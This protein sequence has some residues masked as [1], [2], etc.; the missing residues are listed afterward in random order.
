MIGKFATTTS[1]A[2]LAIFS[3][4]CKRAWPLEE[5]HEQSV[6]PHRHARRPSAP[7]RWYV[8]QSPAVRRR[9]AARPDGAPKG[10]GYGCLNILICAPW[11][12]GR[13]TGPRKWA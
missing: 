8:G 13:R 11:P 7:R 1:I 3:T 9:D 12:L 10:R 6:L 2:A 4:A 5:P